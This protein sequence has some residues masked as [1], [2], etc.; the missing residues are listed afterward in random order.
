MA[1]RTA[2]LLLATVL[3]VVLA[4][5]ALADPKGR[6]PG[7][8]TANTPAG[9]SATPAAVTQVRPTPPPPPA[10]PTTSDP[11]SRYLASPVTGALAVETV[12][13]A[14]ASETP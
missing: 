11:G 13:P 7:P 1:R 12:P 6:R 5:C 3:S 2:R 10:P 4:A 9:P 8:E 14:P